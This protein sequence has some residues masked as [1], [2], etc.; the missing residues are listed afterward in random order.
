MKFK[1]VL[2]DH[3]GTL[4]DSEVVHYQFWKDV[5][6]GLGV[7]FTEQHYR[8][9]YT[10]VSELNTAR[11]LREHFQLAP[12]VEELVEAKRQ[13]AQAFH[14]HHHY[15]L[16]P[17]VEATLQALRHRGVR[18]AVVSGAARF[19]LEANLQACGLA[20]YFECVV[21]GEEMPRNKPAPDAYLHALEALQ[22][23]VGDCVAVEDTFSG[24]SAAKAA[25]LITCAIPNRFS[26][27]QDFSAADHQF[28]HLGEFARW[29]MP[30]TVR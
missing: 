17:E 28:N 22:L 5:L 26:A 8:L 7:A 15:P 29:F 18:M 25:G 20:Q 21:S 19:A 16:M 1:A 2:F 4:A 24:L 23:S 12:S 11:H 30:Q 27:H 9:N 13:V 14:R 6:A 10:G 3:D